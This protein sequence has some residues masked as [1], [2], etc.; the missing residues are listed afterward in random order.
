M[1]RTFMCPSQVEN[2]WEVRV[3]FLCP[4]T[5]QSWLSVSKLFQALLDL[6]HVNIFWGAGLLSSSV[7]WDVWDQ[8]PCLFR[9]CCL[10]SWVPPWAPV[11]IT[12]V[13]LPASKQVASVN[14]S[15]KITCGSLQIDTVWVCPPAPCPVSFTSGIAQ[16]RK[17]LVCWGRLCCFSPVVQN[18]RWNW[19][20]EGSDLECENDENDWV[21]CSLWTRGAQGCTMMWLLFLGQ[22]VH[23]LQTK[24]DKQVT[25]I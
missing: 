14:I 13:C 4:P 23:L 7:W 25:G 9:C 15:G 24:V 19:D 8:H 6:D 22:L 16:E 2:Q 21:Y 20:G 10:G 3:D 12:S 1:W 17:P 18:R 11:G 5:L